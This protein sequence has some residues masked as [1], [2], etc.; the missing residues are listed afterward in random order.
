MTLFTD[1][2]LDQ[3]KKIDITNTGLLDIENVEPLLKMLLAQHAAKTRTV[4]VKEEE[5]AMT[6]IILAEMNVNLTGFVT[7]HEMKSYMTRK[8]IEINE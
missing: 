3:F 5:A 2:L 4:T 1:G 6:E 7:Y 8:Y